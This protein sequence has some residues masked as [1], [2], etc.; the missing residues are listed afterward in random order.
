MGRKRFEYELVPYQNLKSM[1]RF[2]DIKAYLNRMGEQNWMLVDLNYGALLFAREKAGGAERYPSAKTRIDSDP[3]WPGGNLPGS[4]MAE[5]RCWYPRLTRRPE[6]LSGKDRKGSL[7][8]MKGR[9][10]PGSRMQVVTAWF[11]EGKA[12][13]R[14]SSSREL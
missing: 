13:H 10:G 8:P 1:L 9:L 5:K 4:H 3:A 7:L 11:F 14:G 2:E 12:L 6:T